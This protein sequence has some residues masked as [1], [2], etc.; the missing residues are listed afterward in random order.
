MDVPLLL[1]QFLTIAAADLSREETAL[2]WRCL[3]FP[4]RQTIAYRLERLQKRKPMGATA[5]MEA[6]TFVAVLDPQA[7]ILAL[8]RAVESGHGR[9][10][11]AS[12]I[13]ETMLADAADGRWK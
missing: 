6:N 10:S 11:E 7:L 1:H 12:K 9:Q 13:E 3:P 2:L 4:L 8:E 5:I